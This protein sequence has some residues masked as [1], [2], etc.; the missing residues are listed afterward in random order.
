M[1]INW[2]IGIAISIILF[3]IITL[4]F[5]YFAF[6]QDVNLVR[7]D[8]YEAEVSYNERM[9]TISRSKALKDGLN[10][11]ITNENIIL[12]FPASL[13]KS[14]KIHGNITLYRPSNRD[15]DIN[16]PIAIDSGFIQLI[17][18]DNLLSGLWKI[19]VDWEIDSLSYFNEEILMVQ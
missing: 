12:K 3:T 14:S 8:Y 4:S 9:E 17:K 5:V 16:L 10:I 19:Q 6:K 13:S 2:G 1:K 11:S 7:D 18:T 15:K